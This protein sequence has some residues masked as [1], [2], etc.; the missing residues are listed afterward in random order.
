MAHMKMAGEGEYLPLN[1]LHVKHLERCL[2][3]GSAQPP[4][5]RIIP[6]LF[7][8]SILYHTLAIL[9]S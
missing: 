8:P 1:E 6:L 4:L 3:A 9:L 5:A 7:W 2:V